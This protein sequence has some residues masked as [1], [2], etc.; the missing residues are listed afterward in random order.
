MVLM[1]SALGIEI[2]SDQTYGFIQISISEIKVS[3][4]AGCSAGQWIQTLLGF[5][6]ITPSLDTTKA[7]LVKA[8]FG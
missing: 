1:I 6:A 7:R 5:Q 4:W 8:A 2:Q 3:N